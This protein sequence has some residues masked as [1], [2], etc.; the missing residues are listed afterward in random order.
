MRYLALVRIDGLGGTT[1]T[2]WI[3][4]VARYLLRG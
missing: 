3:T 2:A 1:A 4:P